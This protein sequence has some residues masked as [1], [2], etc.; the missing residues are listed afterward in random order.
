MWVGKDGDVSVG[1]EN[2]HFV[3]PHNRLCRSIDARLCRSLIE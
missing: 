2:F 1:G 3:T